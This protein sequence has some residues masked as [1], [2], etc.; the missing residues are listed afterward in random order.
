MSI[1][2]KYLRSGHLILLSLLAFG[3][4]NLNL[5]M[6][7][8]TILLAAWWFVYPGP[9]RGWDILRKNP[10]ALAILALFTIHIIWLVNTQDWESA[11]K[12]LRTKLNLLVLAVAIGGVEHSAKDI[13]R[14]MFWFS[15]GLWLA[16]FTALFNY[17][18]FSGEVLDM[19]EVVG[20]ISHIRL[21]LMMVVAVVAAIY[22]WPVLNRT[23]RI[24]VMATVVAILLFL[25]FI[26]A[27]TGIIVLV[28]V[29][30]FTLF[31]LV[32]RAYGKRQSYAV[33]A[34]V[35]LLVLGVVGFA[36]R[37]YQNY[38]V[39]D[40]VIPQEMEYTKSGD[41]Y[42]FYPSYQIENGRYVFYYLAP[43]ELQNAWNERSKIHLSYDDPNDR[44]LIA[45]LYR[46]L[47][48]KGLHKD[49]EGVMTLTDEDIHRIEAG[50][51]TP[52]YAESSG[53]PL[54]WHVILYSFHVY[55]NS[56]DAT[57]LSLF[58]RFVYWKVASGLIAENFWTGTGT[59]DVRTTFKQ[60]YDRYGIDLEPRYRLRAHNQFLTFFV[61]FGV[62]GLL[63]F[64]A[65]F[66]IFCYSASGDYFAWSVALIM[67]ASCMT[68]DTLETQAGV[69]FFTFFIVLLGQKLITDNSST[70]PSGNR[71]RITNV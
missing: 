40:E 33:G 29:L 12:D 23:W 52:L 65:V 17:F 43:D 8:A 11:G 31:F 3:M 36:W 21:S 45:R 41:P 16:I 1:Q 66:F 30:M 14:V 15:V 4:S 27:A 64:V 51:P 55:F 71:P 50:Y 42:L 34:I 60:A 18:T 7:L 37:Y 2:R 22:Y 19:R 61:S 47:T 53:L 58:Q 24:Y 13:A 48:A 56:G 63:A 67:A 44:D 54:R 62:W 38:F 26:Q 10:P 5:L 35:A 20:E 70:M 28:L 39:S 57:G 6:S 59:G 46:Y 25:N 68:E 49:R 32:R 69:T 9:R